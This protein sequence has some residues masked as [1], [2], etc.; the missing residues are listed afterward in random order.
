MSKHCYCGN[1]C[2][3]LS[4]DTHLQ[5]Q[6][7]WIRRAV[8]RA[9]KEVLLA[10][11]HHVVWVRGYLL[12]DSEDSKENTDTSKENETP[13]IYSESLLGRISLTRH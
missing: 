5:E 11:C 10:N 2:D 12:L 9:K 6:S 3:T 8:I 4:T 13:N 7:E 1:G